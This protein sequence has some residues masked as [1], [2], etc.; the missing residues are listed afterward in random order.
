MM[1]DNQAREK[2]VFCLFETQTAGWVLMHLLESSMSTTCQALLEGANTDSCSQSC[3]STFHH[4]YF[5]EPL[6]FV[7]KRFYVNSCFL[8]VSSLAI[9]TIL[10]HHT[11][12]TVTKD[13][14]PKSWQVLPFYVWP[15]FQGW[16]LSHC[17]LV[18][19]NKENIESDQDCLLFYW[20]LIS[21]WPQLQHCPITPLWL[22]PMASLPSVHGHPC[23]PLPCPHTYIFNIILQN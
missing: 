1:T 3:D 23:V 21:P 9:N 13:Q 8:S 4:S 18:R 22:R 16:I 10:R 5:N 17:L 7:Q 11:G 15:Q 2:S 12:M 14:I 6:W 20:L 19:Q